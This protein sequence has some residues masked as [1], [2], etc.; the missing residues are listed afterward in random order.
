MFSPIINEILSRI[1]NEL[2]SKIISEILSLKSNSSVYKDASF[3]AA[4]EGVLQLPSVHP[5]VKLS[6]VVLRWC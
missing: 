2:L 1:I 6:N 5:T 3:L 4:A